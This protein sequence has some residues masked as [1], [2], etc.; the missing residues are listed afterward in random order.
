MFSPQ[1]RTRL[2]LL[3]GVALAMVVIVAASKLFHVP[4][5]RDFGGSILFEPSPIV[6]FTIVGATIMVCVLLGTLV[7]G[8]VR[9]D[10]GLFCAA[11]GAVS[12]S[13]RSGT[14]GDVLRSRANLGSGATVFILFGIE[15]V[16]LYAV[17]GLAWSVLWVLHRR[18]YLKAD[19]FRDGVEDTEDSLGLKI[20]ALATQAGG[21]ALLMLLLAQND[22]KL[23]VVWAV[24]I[25]SYLATILAYYMYP[26]SPSAW[27]WTGPLLVGLAGYALAYFNMDPND[28][29]WRTGQLRFS[30]APL[31]RALPLDYATAGTAGAILG[32]WMGRRWHRQR[33]VEMGESTGGAA[34]KQE[35]IDQ[36]FE[37]A[38]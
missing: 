5:H 24:A 19:Q 12:L 22:S 28:P 1:H 30:L 6:S 11:V 36:F 35:A 4:A 32:Y 25:S 2:L 21:M 23:Q 18:D 14:V 29:L 20:G 9:F 17:L 8:S 3:A 10:A 16:L 27:L 31:A 7:A 33:M 34:A 15:L 26:I 38:Q 37:K 13:V